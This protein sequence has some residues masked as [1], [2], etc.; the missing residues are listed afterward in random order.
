MIEPRAT[1]ASMVF[2]KK[3]GQLPVPPML[4][5]MIRAGFSLSG[6]PLTLPP[7]AQVTASMV[8]ALVEPHRPRTRTGTILAS[9]ATPATPFL[10]FVRAAIVPATWEPCQLDV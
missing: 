4:I 5:L 6:T 2:W 9:G 10:L 1:A 7:E 8:S 3:R